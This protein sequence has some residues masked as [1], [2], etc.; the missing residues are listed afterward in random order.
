MGTHGDNSKAPWVWRPYKTVVVEHRLD[1]VW[2]S[3]Q[4]VCFRSVWCQEYD[5]KEKKML[6]DCG[7]EVF[8]NAWSA[9]CQ[10][11]S[12]SK[13]PFKL[14]K[15]VES[16]DENTKK[17]KRQSVGNGKGKKRARVLLTLSYYFINISISLRGREM[18]GAV[19][20][21]TSGIY[22]LQ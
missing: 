3:K 2:Q 13:H 8:S 10:D 20:S 22:G 4:K 5:L 1:M 7:S 17:R 9:V 14:T 19:S 11:V 16:G 12:H 6:D 21:N 18:R 15:V